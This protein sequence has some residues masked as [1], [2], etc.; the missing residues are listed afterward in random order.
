MTL[1]LLKT[2]LNRLKNESSYLDS[3]NIWKSVCEA[4]ELTPIC[5]IYIYN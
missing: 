2:E 3:V 4:A 5:I 1:K